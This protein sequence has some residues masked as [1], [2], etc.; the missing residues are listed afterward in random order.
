MVTSCSKKDTATEIVKVNGNKL[1]VTH[2]D[3]ITDTIDLKL[4]ELLE[5]C[6]AIVLE[7]GPDSY[8]SRAHKIA[9]SDNY[10]A[11]KD[12]EK[13]P[14]K[15]FARNGEYLGDIGAIGRG[16][17]EY[18]IS[19][20]GI[21][22]DEKREQLYLLPFANARKIL[23]FGLD[24]QA[25]THIPL[26]FQQRKFKAHVE[27]DIVT[28]LGMPFKND[29]AVVFQQ[30]FTGEL[31]QYIPPQDYH[32]AQ[33]FSSEVQSPNNTG[34]YDFFQLIWSKTPNDTLYHYDTKNNKLFPRFTLAF[35]GEEWPVYIC[36]ELPRHFTAWISGR[37]SFFVDK[38]TLETSYYRLVNDFYGGIEL[39]LHWDSARGIF[40]AALP[41]LTLKKEIKRCL[42]LKQSDDTR[43]RLLDLDSRITEDSN[44]IL[45]IGKY[46]Q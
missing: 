41:A 13:T 42:G 29:S 27:D 31:I 35:E 28:I 11:V 43:D 24:G 5:D 18:N 32:L 8:I 22:I 12:S 44:D 17:D 3:K 14:L 15:L 36:N 7:A 16:P 20:Y 26:R 1:Y 30:T 2:A 45:F 38:N 34:N 23:V 46:R 37:G 33:E 19:L 4:S 9:V 39:D 40:I 25:R 10:I 6:Q 21:Q